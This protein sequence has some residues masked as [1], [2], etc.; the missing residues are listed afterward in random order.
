MSTST[1]FAFQ[2]TNYIIMLV[3]LAVLFI[4]FYIMTIDQEPYG[5]GFFGAA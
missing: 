3:G 1:K 2:K 4:G 5:F